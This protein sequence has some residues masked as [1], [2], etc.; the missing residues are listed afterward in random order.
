MVAIYQQ[1]CPVLFG[2]DAITQIGEKARAF[3]A[4]KAFC[5]CDSGVKASGIADR[6][7][8]YL[9]EAGIETV[10]FDGAL[11]DAPDTVIDEVGARLHGAGFDLVV[12]IGGGSSMDTAKALSVLA[13]HP[14]PIRRY[15]ASGG[16]PPI[17]NSPTKLILI[18]T[19]SGTGSEVTIMSV[20][21]DTET[22]TK[23]AVLRP[24]DL[25][26]VDPSLTLSTP[27]GV[28]ASSGMDALSHA[29]EAYTSTGTNPKNDLLALHAASLIAEHLELA[30]QNG[31]DLEARTALSLASNLAGIAFS[32]ASVHIG[33]CAGHELGLRLHI[34]HGVACALALPV[35]LEFCA[36]ALPEKIRRIAEALGTPVPAGAAPAKAGALAADAVRTL[37]RRVGIPS[38]RTL[39]HERD[40]VLDCA[41]G[42]VSHNWFHIMAPKPVDSAVMRELLGRM[43]DTY[44]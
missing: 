17:L 22:H 11:P 3:R 39:G 2:V 10:C 6:V 5:V 38:L 8:G 1:N 9:K 34:P 44:L 27:S 33:H 28:T 7:I 36:D 21:H 24:A 23:D 16:C 13:D 26:I 18:P 41:E 14:L 19:S 35:T 42:A 12:G 32:D 20:I 31:G 40:A 29:L 4:E 37:M 43:Y 25:A 30:Y 15:F